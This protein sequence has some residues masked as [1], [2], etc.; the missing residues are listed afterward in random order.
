M[1]KEIGFL[2]EKALFGTL[3]IVDID[4]YDKGCYLKD[5]ALNSIS[6]SAEKTLFYSSFIQLLPIFLRQIKEIDEEN[7]TFLQEEATENISNI[8]AKERLKR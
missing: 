5:K 6:K 1:N 7:K 4:N 2:W 3:S 8:L